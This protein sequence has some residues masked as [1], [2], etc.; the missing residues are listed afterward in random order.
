[1]DDNPISDPND[2]N[3]AVTKARDAGQSRITCEFAEATGI[4]HHPTEGSLH[5]YY[6]QLNVIASHLQQY[7]PMA[8]TVVDERPA[9]HL[10]EAPPPTDE[11]LG[12]TFNWHQ[13][14]Q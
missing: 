10:A 2:L 3:A 5:L 4:T 11:E 14:K 6:D 9:I 8:T 12:Q 7:R 13:I 1:M